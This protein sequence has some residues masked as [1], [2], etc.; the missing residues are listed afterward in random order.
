M[1]Q[2]IKCSCGKSFFFTDRDQAY[3]AAQGFSPPKRCRDCRALKKA[4]APGGNASRPAPIVRPRE[5]DPKAD[6]DRRLREM[7]R[8]ADD[9]FGNRMNYGG[10]G[11]RNDRSRFESQTLSKFGNNKPMRRRNFKDRRDQY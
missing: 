2:E 5:N 7:V 3:Y 9:D 1:D 4:N 11:D 8:D 10:R 6:A